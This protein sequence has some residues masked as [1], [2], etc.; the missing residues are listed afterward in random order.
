MEIEYLFPYSTRTCTSVKVLSYFR[1]SEVLSYESTK[2]LSC[3]VSFRDG[4]SSL[5]DLL[6]PY[7]ESTSARKL[8]FRTHEVWLLPSPNKSHHIE[9]KCQRIVSS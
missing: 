2:V 6:L 1:T 3:I 9:L 4:I 8:L 5:N 7:F